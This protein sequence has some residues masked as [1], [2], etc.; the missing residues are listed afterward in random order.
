MCICVGEGR[1]VCGEGV[2]RE[3]GGVVRACIGKG[4]VCGEGVYREGVCVVRACIGK[5]GVW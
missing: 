2:Y 1:G 3:G 5:G 4:Y